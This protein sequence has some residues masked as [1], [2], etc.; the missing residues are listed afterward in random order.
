M[1]EKIGLMG[2]NITSESFPCN[3]CV[4]Q[5]SGGFNPQ[6]GIELCANKLSGQSQQEDTMAH[7][8][9]DQPCSLSSRLY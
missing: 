9:D 5:K 4:D 1:N 7:G 3:F 6:Y 8:K 2:G